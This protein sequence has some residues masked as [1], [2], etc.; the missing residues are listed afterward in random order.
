MGNALRQSTLTLVMHAAAALE[1]QPLAELLAECRQYEAL[2]PVLCPSEWQRGG[3][4]NLADQL[5]ALEAAHAFV[6]K[7]KPLLDRCRAAAG[8]QHG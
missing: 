4:D 7:L 3:A 1:G 2:G 5:A 6:T 8:V